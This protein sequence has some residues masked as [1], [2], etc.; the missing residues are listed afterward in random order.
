MRNL[1]FLKVSTVYLS[2]LIKHRARK[3]LVFSIGRNLS[4]LCACKEHRCNFRDLCNFNFFTPPATHYCAKS[5]CFGAP[6][7]H[8]CFNL[9]Q[10]VKGVFLWLMQWSYQQHLAAILSPKLAGLD[11]KFWL[12]N[13]QN[14]QILTSEYPPCVEMSRELL[15]AALIYMALETSDI[16]SA[17]AKKAGLC[18][19]CAK[20]K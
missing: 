6:P 15:S 9:L 13:I 1:M 8:T 4:P 18:K 5:C 3:S 10:L 14:I 2:R 12:Q 19:D 17:N 20:A 16:Q 11:F 7:I